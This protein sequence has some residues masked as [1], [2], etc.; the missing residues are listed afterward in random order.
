MMLWHRGGERSDGLAIAPQKQGT[1]M[2]LRAKVFTSI[3]FATSAFL[4]VP[5]AAQA[6]THPVQV[7]GAKLKSALLPASTFGPGFKL[8]VAT[9]TGKALLH[10]K[11]KNH[12]PTMSCANFENQALSSYGESAAAVSISTNEST[13][14]GVGSTNVDLLYEQSAY[15]FPSVK[16]A[17]T[18]YSQAHAKYAACKSFS[19]QTGSGGMGDESLKISL[20]SIFKIKMGK[21]RAFRVRE[22]VDISSVAGFSLSF[23]TLVTV[24]GTDVFIVT[25]FSVGNHPVSAKSMLK[26]VDRVMKL[27][28]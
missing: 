13:A 7:S 9:G 11:A 24:E 22:G 19:E 28:S 16:A 25:S 20:K 10:Q 18:F 12:V 8:V 14:I 6:V 15:Q 2:S 17:A 26:L 1:T 4:L 21:Y 23:N 5:T 27:R 3:A